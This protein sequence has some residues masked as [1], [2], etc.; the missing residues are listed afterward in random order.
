MKTVVSRRSTLKL[1]SLLPTISLKS[2]GALDTSNA[3]PAPGTSADFL[4]AT[5][6][7]NYP[8]R[9]VGDA[10]LPYRGI[11]LRISTREDMSAPFVDVKLPEDV[12]SY[13]LAV[14]PATNYYWQLIP[15]DENSD[16]TAL[17]SK[18]NFRTHEPYITDTDDDSLR[19]QNPRVCARWEV[20]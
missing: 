6:T 3:A 13:R 1:L 4:T 9:L 7:W 15:F 20:G 2:M 10:L 11:K 5:L 19:Y 14:A 17:S 8:N 16:V 18:G 12:T